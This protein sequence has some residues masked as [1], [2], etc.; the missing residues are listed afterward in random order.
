MTNE[1]AFPLPIDVKDV[2]AEWLSAALRSRAPGVTVR[3]AELVDS[4]FSTCSKL[5]YRIELDEAGQAAGLPELIIVKGGFEE[6]ARQLAQMHEREV[7]GYRD[8]YP[9]NPLRSP[10]CYFA[11]YDADRRQGIVIMEDLV[12]RGVEFC[13]A[14]K[15]QT[16]EQVADRLSALARFHAG[17]WSSADLLPGGRWGHLPE[18]WP[19]MQDFVDRVLAP[20]AWHDF[21]TAPRGAATSRKFHDQAWI[22]EAMG[23][24]K[25]YCATLPHCVL[26]GDTHLGNCYIEPDGTPGF[27]D[28]LASKGPPL[29]EVSYHVSAALD[30]ANRRLSEGALVQHYLD[31]AARAGA[32]V[33]SFAE[34]M[35]QYAIFLLYGHFIWITTRS[36]YQPEAVNTANAARVSAAMLDHGTY[37]LIEQLS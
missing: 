20:E 18:F 14:S 15:P 27:L 33:P 5:R 26:H 21:I 2:T 23:R 37:E 32:R 29:L 36:K 35:R 17:S 11:G 19:V 8:V 10:A 1:G 34:A 22:V 25:R 12:A 16:H 13:H 7:L 3:S 24:V 31:E 4:V 30:S 6:H 28:T 9:A